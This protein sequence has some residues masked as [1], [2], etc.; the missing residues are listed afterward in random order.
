[1]AGI[2]IVEREP[3]CDTQTLRSHS[4]AGEDL[5]HP[6]LVELNQGLITQDSPQPM[7]HLFGIK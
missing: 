4:N 3:Q 2:K 6:I 1:M 5:E 7:K